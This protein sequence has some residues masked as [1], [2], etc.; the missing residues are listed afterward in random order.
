[1]RE[2]TITL[3]TDEDPE[4]VVL[5]VAAIEDA[6]MGHDESIWLTCASSVREID[7]PEAA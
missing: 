6:L 3:R 5:E 1:M 4:I 2:V 7:E